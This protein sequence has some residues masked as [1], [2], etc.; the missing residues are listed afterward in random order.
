MDEEQ[1]GQTNSQELDKK[2]VLLCLLRVRMRAH[3]CSDQRSL[4][5]GTI[6]LTQ[7]RDLAFSASPMHVLP[8]LALLLF[9]FLFCF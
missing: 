3:A 4:S 7:A 5:L 9:L 2:A 8:C 6:V 1:E